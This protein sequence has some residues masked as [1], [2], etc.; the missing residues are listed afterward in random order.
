MKTFNTPSIEVRK[1]QIADVITTS[2]DTP[3]QSA[4]CLPD[5]RG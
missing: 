4:N 5:D 3:A 2:T 1:F